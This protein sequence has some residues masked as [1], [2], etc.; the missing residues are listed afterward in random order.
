MPSNSTTVMFD[1]SCLMNESACYSQADI[2]KIILPDIPVIERDYQAQYSQY[3]LPLGQ[4]N[5]VGLVIY[6]SDDMLSA[7][8]GT[9]YRA[10]FNAVNIWRKTHLSQV[11]LNIS[12]PSRPN[13]P[14]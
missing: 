14:N 8:I 11:R 13:K 1:G 5:L 3:Q 4:F 6:L 9:L 2:L 12:I 7:D 10:A